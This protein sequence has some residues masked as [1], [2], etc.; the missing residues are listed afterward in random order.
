MRISLF[1]GHSPRIDDLV[2]GART[3]AGAGFDGIWFP[4]SAG[5]DALTTCAV[6]ALAVP[7]LHIG[8]A[9]VP[10]QGRHPIPLA[11][12]ALSVASVAGA[13][14][15][16][17]GVGVTHPDV[18]EGWYG[19][20]YRDVVDLCAEELP[21]L[22]TLIRGEDT[23]VVG[24]HLTARTRLTVEGPVPGMVLA[25]LGPRML[26]LAG[27][28][29]DGTVTWMTG[30]VGLRDVIVPRMRAAA[31]AAGRPAPR[32]VAG[33]RV[34]VTDR[35]GAARERVRAGIVTSLATMPSYRRTVAAER[36]D[37]PAAV[38]IVGDASAVSE[39]LDELEAV[40]V[41][42]LLAYL[43]GEDDE[44]ARSLELLGDRAS[45]RRSSTR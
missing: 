32:V 12:Q 26:D 29:T 36:S 20:S 44:N 41:T 34:V 21:A 9:V 4:Q 13:G 11:Q 30:P 6:A 37:D 5:P 42:E 10:I 35:P 39:R 7:D 1:G 25:A 38:A 19:I 27:R 3:A 8:T 33:M 16:T 14:R 15:F 2:A 22:A 43:V 28:F 45:T 18:S 17:L 23:T 31:E 40:G 24:R